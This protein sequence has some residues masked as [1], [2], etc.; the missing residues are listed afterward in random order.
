MKANRLGR[1]FLEVDTVLDRHDVRRPD[2]FYFSTPRLH[3]VGKKSVK[4]PPDLCVE[5]VSFQSRKTDRKKKFDLYR[6]SGVA[7]YWIV[8]PAIRVI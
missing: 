5:V 8:D 6:K 1:V 4:R 7:F 3:F 2:L